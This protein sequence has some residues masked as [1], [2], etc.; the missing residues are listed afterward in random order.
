MFMYSR[1]GKIIECFHD[2]MRRLFPIHTRIT[3]HDTLSK[4]KQHLSTLIVFFFVCFWWYVM[5]N[6]EQKKQCEL[7]TPLYQH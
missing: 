4:K 7:F 3:R 5:S 1:L 2:C 6:G